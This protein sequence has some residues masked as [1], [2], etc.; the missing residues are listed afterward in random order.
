[1]DLL[2]PPGLSRVSTSRDALCMHFWLLPSDSRLVQPEDEQSIS[3]SGAWVRSS[4][5][6]TEWKLKCC[7]GNKESGRQ[8][9][10]HAVCVAAVEVLTIIYNIA[11]YKMLRSTYFFVSK[12]TVSFK[13][14]VSEVSHLEERMLGPRETTEL[15]TPCD[16]CQYLSE[17]L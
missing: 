9:R 7:W 10:T 2:F 14:G 15:P 6:A 17:K 8:I 3:C 4:S 16:I 11:R 1:M 13:I 5:W 12:M